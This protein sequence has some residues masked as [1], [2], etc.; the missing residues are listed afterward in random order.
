MKCN[1][2]IPY[3]DPRSGRSGACSC[4]KKARH[5]FRLTLDGHRDY[6]DS[7]QILGFCDGCVGGME[8]P[9]NYVRSRWNEPGVEHLRG[10]V[11]VVTPASESDANGDKTRKFREYVKDTFK[12]KFRQ[13]KTSKLS[14][15]EW[16]E[17][18][19]E[20]LQEHVIETVMKT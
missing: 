11:L 13:K 16:M 10:K 19:N 15:E 7:E 9:S 14:Q 18:F 1:K 3:T 20:A 17:L 4:P 5:F 8:V 12:S 2:R 6:G